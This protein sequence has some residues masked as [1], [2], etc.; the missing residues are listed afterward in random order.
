M[1]RQEEHGRLSE[2]DRLEVGDRIKTGQ[3]HAEVA[4]AVGC[5][6]KSI[7]RLLIRTGGFAPRGRNRS[8]LHLSPS[9]RRSL[10]A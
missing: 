10:E 1:R 4:A 8:P 6:T 3:T 7:Q 9:E 2:A 5:S